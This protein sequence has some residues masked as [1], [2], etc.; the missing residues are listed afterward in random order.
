[1]PVDLKVQR[2]RCQVLGKREFKF[3][4]VILLSP[5]TIGLSRE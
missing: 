4:H 3:M 1:V 5:K 2:M